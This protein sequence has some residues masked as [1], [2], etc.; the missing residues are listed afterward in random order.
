MKKSILVLLVLLSTLLPAKAQAANLEFERI[1]LRT[2]TSTTYQTGKNTYRTEISIAP[3]Y[4]KNNYNDDKELW[5][6]ID[7]SFDS[8]NSIT[9]APYILNVNTGNMS[10]S[11]HNKKTGEDSTIGLIQIGTGQGKDKKNGITPVKNTGNITW[12]D[13]VSGLDVSIIATSTSV[14][15]SRTIKYPG[16]ATDA[17]FDITGN[18]SYSARNNKGKSLTVGK[19]KNGKNVTENVSDLNNNDYP[20]IIDPVVNINPGK[21]GYILSTAPDAS[22]PGG[23]LSVGNSA[24]NIFRSLLEFTLPVDIP[25]NNATISATLGLYSVVSPVG[26]NIVSA[27]LTRTG[28]VQ[29]EASWNNYKAVTPWTTAG[30]DYTTVGNSITTISSGWNY[31]DVKDHINVGYP[32][33]ILLKSTNEVSTVSTDFY[34]MSVLNPSLRPVL[35]INYYITTPTV[36]TNLATYVARTSA[37]LNGTINDDGGAADN[38]SFEYGTDPTFTVSTNTTWSTANYSTGQTFFVDLAGLTS[39]TLYYFRAKAWNLIGNA[40]GLSANFT[41]WPNNL[42]PSNFRALASSTQVVLSWTSGNG[43]SVTLIQ[44][45]EG[46]YPTNIYDG[47]TAFNS[48][49]NSYNQLGLISGHTYYYSAWGL[50]GTFVSANYT[51]TVITIPLG[52]TTNLPSA[53]PTMPLNWFLVPDYTRM[54]WSPI[55]PFVNTFLDSLQIPRNTG[56]VLWSIFISVLFG[57]GLYTASRDPVPSLIALSVGLALHTALG[58]LPG[59]VLGFSLIFGLGATQIGQIWKSQQYGG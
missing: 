37:R 22:F 32:V 23:D 41:T 53:S 25:S 31:W 4:Y 30:G 56:W 6:P 45:K 20:V 3:K 13:Y 54:S 7:L 40:T 8:N 33:E 14:A 42:E 1:D 15:F 43:S 27:N 48:T 2:E 46:T 11:V 55:Y 5:K 10:L 44:Y 21:S 28:W 19:I 39:S 52:A 26:L 34:G 16:V 58:T 36:V 57:V 29:S 18:V 59:W 47:L 9:K 49:G 12:L 51:T 35:T 50:S 38:V 17:S 24:G